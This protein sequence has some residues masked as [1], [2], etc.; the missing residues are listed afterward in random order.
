MAD[1]FAAKAPRRTRRRMQVGEMN[2]IVAFNLWLTSL[3]SVQLADNRA[4]PAQMARR[5]SSEQ[6]VRK[7]QISTWLSMTRK[8]SERSNALN[9]QV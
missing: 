9:Q 1:A 5:F 4:Y 7:T 2:F 3:K 6:K 8:D